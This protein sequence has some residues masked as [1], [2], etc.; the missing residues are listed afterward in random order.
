[1]NEYSTCVQIFD[2]DNQVEGI[3]KYSDDDILVI[4]K[5]ELFTL[6][7]YQGLNDEL[8]SGNT[9]LRNKESR[10]EYLTSVTEIRNFRIDSK[11]YYFVGICG[12]GMKPTV[13]TSTLIRCAMQAKSG[14]RD[15]SRLLPLMNVSFV[16]NG[17]L[18]VVPFP[19]KYLREYILS[20]MD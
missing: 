13:Q 18:T 3:I 15:F 16:R 20:V 11:D 6:P 5:T 4:R 12:T 14:N 19:F 8:K 17:Q 1:M 9:A 10:E 2:D 7:E